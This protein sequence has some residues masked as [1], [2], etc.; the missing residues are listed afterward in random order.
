MDRQMDAQKAESIEWL[1]NIRLD[2]WLDNIFGNSAYILMQK[3][4][5]ETKISSRLLYPSLLK[6]ESAVF[7]EKW[8]NI[9]RNKQ[10]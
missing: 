10:L 9:R 8:L 7:A 2:E 5:L 6:A 4:I 3:Y 1:G